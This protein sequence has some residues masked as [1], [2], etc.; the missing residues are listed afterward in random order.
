MPISPH[1][2]TPC[3]PFYKR[4]HHRFH[5][6]QLHPW[7]S[8]PGLIRTNRQQLHCFSDW[9]IV[10]IIK[11]VYKYSSSYPCVCNV[12]TPAPHPCF[13]WTVRSYYALRAYNTTNTNALKQ[14]NS[15][16]HVVGGEP[17]ATRV[18]GDRTD[19]NI[20]WMGYDQTRPQKWRPLFSTILLTFPKLD[21]SVSVVRRSVSEKQR[22]VFDNTFPHTDPA[23]TCLDRKS[24][25]DPSVWAGRKHGA[26]HPQKTLSSINKLPRARTCAAM[27]WWNHLAPT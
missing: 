7:F 15:A 13:R 24:T 1:S 14:T 19:R 3:D 12:S 17:A 16:T 4:D 26:L 21:R 11:H 25:S 8:S 2:N 10:N 9:V 6:P 20:W 22:H 5:I 27:L 18:V 23:P